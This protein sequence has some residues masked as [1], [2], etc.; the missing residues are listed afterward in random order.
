[1][2]CMAVCVCVCVCVCVGVCIQW[3]GIYNANN[4]FLYL[5]PRDGLFKFFRQDLDVSFGAYNSSSYDFVKRNIWTWTTT[6]TQG[7]GYFL[8]TRILSQEVYQRRYAYYLNL[9]ISKYYSLDADPQSLFKARFDWM[10]RLVE[11]PVR[12]D[13]FHHMDNAWSFE[14]AR[15]N[16]YQTVVHPL[17]TSPQNALQFVGIAEFVALRARSAIAQLASPPQ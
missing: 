10:Y 6:P 16:P 4:Y 15:D 5:D 11:E 3:D 13:Y 14:E 1:M 17:P 12:E 9:L 8:P 7:R 2:Y